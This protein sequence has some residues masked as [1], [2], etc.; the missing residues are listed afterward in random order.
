MARMQKVEDDINNRTVDHYTYYPFTPAPSNPDLLAEISFG[1][2][3]EGSNIMKEHKIPCTIRGQKITKETLHECPAYYYE[4]SY[5]LPYVIRISDKSGNVLH[6]EA[7]PGEGVQTF[8][9]DA[10]G[11]SGYLKKAELESAYASQQNTQPMMMASEA[12]GAQLDQ[13]EPAL[14]SMC[15]YT[16][17][18]RKLSI[19]SA[20]GK[21][22]DYAALETAQ[23]LALNTFDNLK[24]TSAASLLTNLAPALT[25]WKQE[26]ATL[27]MKQDNSR[28]NRSIATGLY[29][30]VALAYAYGWQLDS[31]AA[32]ADKAQNLV[33]YA[34]SL[35]AKEDIAL[36]SA[37]IKERRDQ[38]KAYQVQAKQ[39]NEPVK[40][41]MLMDA[42]RMKSKNIPYTA[43]TGKSKYD[44]WAAPL[45][46]KKE[47]MFEKA[48]ETA[49]GQ[50][51]NNSGGNKYEARVQKNGFQ[52][53]LLMITSFVDGK[54]DML[55]DDV[56]SITYL[57]ELNVTN[58]S[59]KK[60]PETISNLTELRRLNLSNNQLTTLPK[61]LQQCKKLKML[62]LKG[63]PISA[64]EIQELQQALPECKIKI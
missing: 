58:N 25:T 49:L 23:K 36:L 45:V 53:Y 47:N 63:N 56:C 11:L 29:A 9:Y 60:I 3:A 15:F 32:Y 14:Q 42:I 48:L 8:G 10:S 21:G 35:N 51:K 64:A 40:A 18:T 55:P 38:V 46:K 5:T 39:S 20:A 27:D 44:E 54:M 30:N 1:K 50:T 13:L 2:Y 7:F 16:P 12:M 33:K 37:D 24:K 34:I 6:T 19:S 17:V 57:N 62:N 28:I 61:G 59:L 22:F 31:A 41:P 43:I 4:R 52:G 26:L